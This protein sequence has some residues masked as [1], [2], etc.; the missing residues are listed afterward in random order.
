MTQLKILLK[1]SSFNAKS[2]IDSIDFNHPE[3]FNK[4]I[5]LMTKAKRMDFYGVGPSNLIGK[6][7]L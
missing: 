3:T 4:V 2:I 6:M 7:R 1:V 5:E